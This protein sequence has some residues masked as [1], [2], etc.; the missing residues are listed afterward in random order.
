[1]LQYIF[2]LQK[3]LL[4]ISGNRV[5]ELVVSGT[6]CTFENPYLNLFWFKIH[7]FWNDMYNLS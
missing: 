5:T 3:N 7:T 2:F 4:G 6:Q 1:M